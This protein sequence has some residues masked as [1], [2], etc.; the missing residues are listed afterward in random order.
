M[1]KVLLALRRVQ[2]GGD[3]AHISLAIQTDVSDIHLDVPFRL[4]KRSRERVMGAG[5][6]ASVQNRY[7]APKVYPV[8]DFGNERGLLDDAIGRSLALV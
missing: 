4:L 8:A 6:R 5:E 7:A 1:D 3:V 2:I